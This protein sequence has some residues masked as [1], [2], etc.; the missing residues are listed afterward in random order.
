MHYGCRMMVCVLPL[1]WWPFLPKKPNREV[2]WI[3]ST[4][5][6]IEIIV[7]FELQQLLHCYPLKRLYNVKE[8]KARKNKKY[9]LAIRGCYLYNMT[10]YHDCVLNSSQNDCGCHLAIKHIHSC[11]SVTFWYFLLPVFC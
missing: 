9:C 3:L 5:K 11:V 10:L 1:I 6:L 2:S 7:D 4:V 8:Q